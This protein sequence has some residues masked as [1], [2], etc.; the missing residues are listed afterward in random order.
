MGL[1]EGSKQ[2]LKYVA[3]TFIVMFIWWFIFSII[4]YSMINLNTSMEINEDTK[5]INCV[6]TTSSKTE[7]IVEP[8]TVFQKGLNCSITTVIAIIVA[9]SGYKKINVPKKT[10]E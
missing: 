7:I 6:E 2:K 1:T 3:L 9:I 5:V 10:S 8:L 4:R